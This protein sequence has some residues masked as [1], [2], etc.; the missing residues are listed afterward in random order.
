MMKYKHPRYIPI[1]TYVLGF[2]GVLIQTRSPNVK[3]RTPTQLAHQSGVSVYF[4]N[5]FWDVPSDHVRGPRCFF[6]AYPWS[7]TTNSQGSKKQQRKPLPPGQRFSGIRRD[8][9]SRHP[10]PRGAHSLR[11]RCLQWLVHRQ[12]V[13]RPSQWSTMQP[14]TS[15]GSSGHDHAPG[16]P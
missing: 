10:C 9:V 12:P 2:L 16:S 11:P 14:L 6:P 4:A 3:N 5:G 8:T 15:L 1:P 7:C 13:K